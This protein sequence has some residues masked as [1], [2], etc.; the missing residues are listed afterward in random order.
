MIIICFAFCCFL[1]AHKLICEIKISVTVLILV[2]LIKST[3]RLRQSDFELGFSLCCF[4]TKL[5]SLVILFILGE[6]SAL[7]SGDLSQLALTSYF[8]RVHK[9]PHIKQS[10]YPLKMFVFSLL[11]E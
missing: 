1:F 3:V 4:E 10:S 8:N 5:D 2:K 7:H 6:F 11:I 9:E